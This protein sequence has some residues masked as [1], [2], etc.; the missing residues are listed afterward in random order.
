MVVGNI[1][2]MISVSMLVCEWE[3]ACFFYDAKCRHQEADLS[4]FTIM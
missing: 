3:P 2:V 1:A 4:S